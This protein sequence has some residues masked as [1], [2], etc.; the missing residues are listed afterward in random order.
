[1]EG[2]GHTRMKARPMMRA[3]LMPLKTRLSLELDRLSFFFNYWA[4]W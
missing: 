2:S 1:M 4:S 3:S